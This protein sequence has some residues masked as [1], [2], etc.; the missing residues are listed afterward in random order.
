VITPAL[1]GHRTLLPPSHLDGSAPLI[2]YDTQDVTLKRNFGV[3]DAAALLTL[4]NKGTI[5]S[6][7]DTTQATTGIRWVFRKIAVA[8]KMNNLSALQ[9]DGTRKMSSSAF[10]AIP[11]PNIIAT[12][13]RC[14]A[15]GSETLNNTSGTQTYFA[16]ANISV[17]AGNFA[18]SGV[19]VANT[20]HMLAVTFN[21][22]PS[23]VSVDGTTTAAGNLGTNS[24]TSVTLGTDGASSYL[25]GFFLEQM[26]YAGAGNLPSIASLNAYGALKF[27][28]LPQ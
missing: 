18:G 2:W 23:Q 27:G 21:G 26:V 9:N 11:Q 15:S 22:S 28:A 8:G 3:L 1:G 19:V 10:T 4:K 20:F 12:F 17:Y 13:M 5:G 16:G 25:T 6:A 7:A 14:A 24:H